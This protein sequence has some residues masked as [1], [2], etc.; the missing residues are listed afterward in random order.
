MKTGRFLVLLALVMGL[1]AGLWQAPA[2]AEMLGRIGQ[3]KTMYYSGG[4][5]FLNNPDGT[6]SP[7]TLGPGQTFLMTEF[8]ARFYVTDPATQTGPYRIYFLAPNSANLYLFNLTDFIYPGSQT[9]SG[10]T[11]EVYNLNPGYLF[12]VLPTL[13][14]KQLPPPPQ[15]SNSGPVRTGTFYVTARGYVYP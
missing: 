5:W 13:Q 11:V 14:V 15:P 2:E 9:V 3:I 4:N 10:G 8:H 12:S 1:L 6:T 7:F